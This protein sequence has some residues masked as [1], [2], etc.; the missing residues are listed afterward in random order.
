MSPSAEG[1]GLRVRHLRRRLLVAA[2]CLLGLAASRPAP[3]QLSG[4]EFQANTYTTGDQWRPAVAADS[5]GNFVLIWQSSYNQDGYG[6]GLFGQRFDA[7]GGNVGGEFQVNSYTTGDQYEFDLASDGM[8]NFLVAW[9]NVIPHVAVHV[10][11]RSFDALGVPAGAE[12]R[13]SAFTT[14]SGFGPKVAADGQGNF[15][16]VWS[17]PDAS[18][19]GVFGRR[20][21]ST[22]APLAGEFQVNTYI[23]EDQVRPL[24][25]A[26][27]AG[28]FVVVWSSYGQDGAGWGVFG[29]RFDSTG[30]PAGGEF[31]VSNYTTWPQQ[32]ASAVAMNGSGDFVVAWESYGQ[33]GS[34]SGVFARRFDLAGVAQGNEFQVNSY[35]TGLQQSAD[36]AMGE[37]GEFLVAWDNPDQFDSDIL[38]QHYD[39]AGI[40]EGSTFRVNSYTTSFQDYPAVS[41][42]PSGT[43]VV[44]WG[45]PGDGMWSAVHGQRLAALVFA[46][47][48]AEGAVCGWSASQGSG[49]TCPP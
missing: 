45:G 37:S 31:Q 32:S 8:G 3:G 7:V 4:P 23:T 14:S 48:F 12:F 13:V 46:D 1:L 36:V 5:S 28:E 16:V 9:T 34:G 39:S 47:G 25:A 42:S 30:S 20:F 49:D 40:R 18:R 26:S 35:T 22:G 33:D 41:S 17:A 15:I 10:V 43:F 29:Q 27:A 2:L 38:A 44:A 21:S 11:A 6:K 19:T 24:V